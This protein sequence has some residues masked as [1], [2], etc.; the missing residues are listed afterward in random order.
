MSI[1]KLCTLLISLPLS[2]GAA[3]QANFYHPYTHRS[4]NLITEFNILGERC[5][6]TS[7]VDALLN[8]N[9]PTVKRSQRFAHKHFFP[10]FD[11]PERNECV[12]SPWRVDEEAFLKDSENSLFVFVVR[13]H[14]DWVRSFFLQPFYVPH[15]NMKHGFLHFL[16]SEWTINLT[17]LACDYYKENRPEGWSFTWPYALDTQYY[18]YNVYLGRNFTNIFE[19]RY[20]KTLNYLQI[21]SKVKNFI[22][23][24]YEDVREDPEGCVNFISEFYGVPRCALF[25]PILQYK[26][27]DSSPVLFTEKAYEPLPAYIQVFI[28]RHINYDIEKELGYTS[29]KLNN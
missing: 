28:Q 16:K 9:F 20:Y 10:W 12:L 26:G 22:F 21:G 18:D 8:A 11:L 24:R 6:G 1:H 4:E 14:E 13:N 17:I 7:F 29:T 5:S 15:V 3:E 27:V 23:L 2:V 19:L 25:A